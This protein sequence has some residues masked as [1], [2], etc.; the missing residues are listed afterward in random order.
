MEKHMDE[1]DG[2]MASRK[3][4]VAVLAMGLIFAGGVIAARSDV[5]GPQFAPLIGGIEAVLA[6]YLGSNVGSKW[7][8]KKHLDSKLAS[9]ETEEEPEET[10][11][12][13][14]PQA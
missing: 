13:A 5:F 3:F 7:V 4:W 12:P 11:A 6:M 8:L 10:P 9:G 2:G 14:A 1:R